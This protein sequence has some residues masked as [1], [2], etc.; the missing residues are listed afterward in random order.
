M[1]TRKAPAGVGR[2]E[3]DMDDES[4]TLGSGRPLDPC[5]AQALRDH[6]DG[7]APVEGIGTGGIEAECVERVGGGAAVAEDAGASL[8]RDA[9][10]L[11]PLREVALDR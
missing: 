5:A 4:W 6:R 9:D 3:G 10:G 11:M 8:S 1:I 7:A 2:G